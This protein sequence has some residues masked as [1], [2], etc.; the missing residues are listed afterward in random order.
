[1]LDIPGAFLHPDKDEM[2]HMLL[3]GELAELM[4]WVDPKLYRQYI[5][6]N[7]KGESVLFEKCKRQCM[8]C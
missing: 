4:V 7:A 6:K 8:G 2:V 5:T 3:R 1:M